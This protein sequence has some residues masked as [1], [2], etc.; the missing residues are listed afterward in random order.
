MKSEAICIRKC[1]QKWSWHWAGVEKSRGVGEWK[2]KGET[3]LKRE[4]FISINL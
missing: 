3:K 4:F 1:L 2:V